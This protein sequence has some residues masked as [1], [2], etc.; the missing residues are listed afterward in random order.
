MRHWRRQPAQERSTVA[1]ADGMDIDGG[2]TTNSTKAPYP[3]AKYNI[4]ITVPTYTDEQYEK[5]LV[6]ENWSREE[7]DYLL[8]LIKD[9]YQKWPVIIDRYEYVPS[10]KQEPTSQTETNEATVA[11][12]TE[13]KERDLEALKERY[14]FICA[15]MMEQSFPN[16]VADMNAEEFAT[17]EQYTKFRPQV[18]R[19]RKNLAWE[20]SKR[21]LEEVKEE[22]YLLSE[23]Q[24]I[25]MGAQRF[26]TE[27]AEL[28][29]RLEHAVAPQ[30]DQRQPEMSS[31]SLHALWQ[32]L[33]QI[34][35]SR[36][37][38]ARTSVDGSTA[39]S[40]AA[41]AQTPASAGGHR[42]SI[43]VANQKKGS[44]S[45]A[46]PVRTL[47]AR[48]EARFGVSNPPERIV[49]GIAFR[50]DKLLKLRQ[51]KSQI[52]TQKIA[53]ALTQL[54]IPELIPLPTTKVVQSFENLI[55]KV[56][57]MLDARK[58]A[59]KEEIELATAMA[60]K[61]EIEKQ[62]REKEGIPEPTGDIS[63]DTKGEGTNAQAEPNA[64][65][66]MTDAP[67]VPA[68]EDDSA[69]PSSSHNTRTN[70]SMSVLSA[71]SSRGSRRKK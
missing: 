19:Q 44:I 32:Q 56:N 12:P 5:Y 16:G 51:A 58:A 71:T 10:S 3:F 29:Q 2:N 47:S 66:E 60:V 27:R 59:A 28:R 31:A 50:N 39:Q 41:G 14:Y 18:E 30:K 15:K 8:N 37:P 63:E 11:R 40:P 70:R 42:D 67:A 45:Q 64:D 9:Y 57:L 33:V 6:D 46:V 36:K 53:Q 38:R 43:S 22:E 17:H 4:E 7:T 1:D 48:D 65:V 23:L 35:R 24:R 20:L 49:S 25:M 69:R 34:D 55:Q 61:A 26:E 54:D 68:T 21:K 13:T 52:Q 62:K